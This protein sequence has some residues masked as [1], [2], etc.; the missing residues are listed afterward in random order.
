MRSKLM[1]F[2]YASQRFSSNLYNKLSTLTKKV[3]NNPD[4]SAFLFTKRNGLGQ[5]ASKIKSTTISFKNY[6]TSKNSYGKEELTNLLNTDKKDE[7]KNI[8]EIIKYINSPSENIQT[9][10]IKIVIT[11][12]ALY[13]FILFE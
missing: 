12:H 10:I 13:F 6:R 9:I 7:V 11:S 8:N 5:K 3:L 2:N 4:L 1:I